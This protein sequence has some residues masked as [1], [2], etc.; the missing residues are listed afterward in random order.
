M[1]CIVYR[2]QLM[3]PSPDTRAQFVET[4]SSVTEYFKRECGALGSRLHVADDGA[5]FAYAQ[6][7]SRDVFAAT[8]LHEPGADFLKLR[9][10]WAELCEPTEVIFAGEM[11]ADLFAT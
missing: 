1:Y 10:T 3:A 9:L 2:F 6:W 8:D 5:Y 4:W 11:V 7:P